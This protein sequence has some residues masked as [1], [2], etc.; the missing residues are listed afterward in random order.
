LR[1]LEIPYVASK[2]L[3][4]ISSKNLITIFTVVGFQFVDKMAGAMKG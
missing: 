2:I 3:K 1:K 4:G